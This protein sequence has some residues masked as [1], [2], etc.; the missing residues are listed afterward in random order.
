M[1]IIVVLAIDLQVSPLQFYQRNLD[2]TLEI[3]LKDLGHNF[4]VR[5]KAPQS[6]LVLGR[7]FDATWDGGS[8][9][10]LRAALLRLGS[11]ALATSLLHGGGVLD[12][13]PFK[14]DPFK[15]LLIWK[16]FQRRVSFSKGGGQA[17]CGCCWIVPTH[18][19]TKVCNES[20]LLPK[21]ATLRTW[22]QEPC[23]KSSLQAL[24]HDPT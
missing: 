9:L 12:L 21:I 2:P 23:N 7:F 22:G 17:D 10:V 16:T 6:P 3:P 19:R 15:R 24:I 1:T 5:P 18:L 4:R 14:L 8:L 20:Q 11:G 13:R